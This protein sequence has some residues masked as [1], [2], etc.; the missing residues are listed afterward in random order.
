MAYPEA[1]GR[2][3]PASVA[4]VGLFIVL[5]ERDERTDE[6]QDR[7]SR[8]VATGLGFLACAFDCVETRVFAEPV[9]VAVELSVDRQ[10][11]A[12]AEDCL[13]HQVKHGALQKAKSRLR[14][15]VLCSWRRQPEWV[16]Q[17][18][19]P[20]AGPGRKTSVPG[21][22]SKKPYRHWR[23]GPEYFRRNCLTFGPCVRQRMLRLE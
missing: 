18:W 4:S 5:E 11:V 3:P 6:R 17:C 22:G 8:C 15:P 9:A 1:G 14:L 23:Y 13:E 10:F 2:R 20:I 21:L 19:G 7:R 12:A 16:N